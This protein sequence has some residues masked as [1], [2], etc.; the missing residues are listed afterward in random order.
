MREAR[1][2]YVDL[3]M[4]GCQ[5]MVQGG[6]EATL[7]HVAL[8]IFNVYLLIFVD[9]MSCSAFLLRC[10]PRALH[11]AGPFGLTGR[12]HYSYIYIYIYNMHIYMYIYICIYIHIYIYYIYIYV[13]I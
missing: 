10:A 7:A 12:I 5:F 1:H 8:V 4:A 3:F 6:P 2:K 11:R 9:E 13:Y